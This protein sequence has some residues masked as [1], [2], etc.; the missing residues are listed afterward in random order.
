MG[1]KIGPKRGEDAKYRKQTYDCS[2]RC[3]RRGH[4]RTLSEAIPGFHFG[5]LCGYFL[6]RGKWERV[7]SDKE[8]LC[9]AA[10]PEQSIQETPR[11]GIRAGQT[12]GQQSVANGGRIP[13]SR[14]SFL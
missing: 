14:G 12:D 13:R 10:K 5:H 3:V 8:H 1:N 7:Q 9:S 11:A 2:G 4:N 6:H